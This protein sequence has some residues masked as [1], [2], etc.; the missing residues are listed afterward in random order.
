MNA[1]KK[2]VRT[3][4]PAATTGIVVVL[5]MLIVAILAPVISPYDPTIG[6]VL[7][8]LQPPSPVHWLGTDEAGRDIFSRLLWGSR[9]VFTG[10]LI[11]VVCAAALAVTLALIASW[12]GGW[13]DTL[14][15][16]AMDV[17]FAFPNLLLA[18]LAIA[19]FGADQWIAALSL[20]IAYT[21]YSMRVIRSVAMR[22][23]G[24]AYIESSRIQGVPAPVIVTRHVLPNLLPHI[25]TGMTINF[26]FAIIELAALSFL[27]MG[28]QL[29]DADWGL[30]VS[31]GKQ[32]LIKGFPMESISAGICI[33]VIV[34]AVTLIGERARTIFNTRG[35]VRA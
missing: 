29:P 8:K 24:L 31:T 15:S 32:S 30:M 25:V 23:R 6:S 35:G 5:I 9:S 22:E 28:V 14:L 12:F 19:L 10:A 4:G 1:V 3:L 34:V 27:G 18:I 13:V 2:L 17:L 20:G 33:A 21:P 7:Q 26:A 16:R 11:V